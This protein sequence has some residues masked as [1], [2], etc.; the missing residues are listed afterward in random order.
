MIKA[1]ETRYKGY[2]FRSRLE[3]RWAVFF[4]ALGLKWE[5]EPE[6]FHTL[7]G[8]YLPDFRVTTPQGKPIW[9]EIKPEGMKTDAKF[10]AFEKQLDAHLETG[11]CSS[12]RA[13]LLSGDPVSVFSDPKIMICPRCGFIS[14]PAY[15]F[16][17]DRC[18]HPRL[19]LYTASVGCWPCDVETPCGSGNNWEDGVLG[20]GTY[21]HKGWIMSPTRTASFSWLTEAAVK[22]R[23]ARFEHGEVPA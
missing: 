23:S 8:P 1:I 19:D 10:S 5:Y 22:A 16:T 2:R 21:P 9:Y 20:H 6:G 7:E 15:G 3:A 13:A 18:D 4:E 11:Q 17:F 14:E 12:S